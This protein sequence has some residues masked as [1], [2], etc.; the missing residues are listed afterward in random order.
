MVVAAELVSKCFA[1]VWIV[2]GVD[3]VGEAGGVFVGIEIDAGAGEAG[4]FVDVG[5]GYGDALAG[6]VDGVGGSDV[7]LVDVVG[8]LVECLLKVGALLEGEFAAGGV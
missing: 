2:G 5:D 1:L 3:Y 8:I 7:E 6:L 4:G